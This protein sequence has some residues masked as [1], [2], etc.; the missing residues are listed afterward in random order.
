METLDNFKQYW[1]EKNDKSASQTFTQPEMEKVIK[2]RMHAGLKDAF[3]YFWSVLILLIIVFALLTHVI[4]KYNQN[5][6]IFYLAIGGMVIYIPFAI[7]LF[8]QFKRLANPD[9]TR[10]NSLLSI[11]ENI[12]NKLSLL[13]NFFRFKKWYELFLIPLSCAIAVSI[14]FELYVPGG[15]VQNL[16]GSVIIFILSIAACVAAIYNENKRSFIVPMRQ[17]R[18]LL[19]EFNG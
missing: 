7:K 8:R 10:G 16:R 19:D 9:T 2:K 18:A 5:N 17:L 12:L 6:T 13:N 1:D 11:R 3:K 14:I 4:I 15:V